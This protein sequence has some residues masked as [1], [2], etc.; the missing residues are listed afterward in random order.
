M[1]PVPKSNEAWLKE[2]AAAYADARETI[3]FGPLV[4]AE[5]READLFHLAPVV[6]L[7]IRGIKRT[8][9]VLK[10]ATDAAL[11]SYVATG[12]Q[13]PEVFA[14]P[15]LAFAFCY[16]AAHFGLDLLTEEKIG[17]VMDFVVEHE[18]RLA[19]LLRT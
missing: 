2:I 3:P 14:K 9:A 19:R 17:A 12:A 18:K 1:N 4:D 10:K 16:L 6:C 11:V 8:K 5:I 7:K 13:E 15:H